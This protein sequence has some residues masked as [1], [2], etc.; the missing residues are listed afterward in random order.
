MDWYEWHNKYM[1]SPIL[2]DRL[3]T[4]CEQIEEFL[5][6]APPGDIR[7]LSICAGDGR[8]LLGALFDH[9]RAEDVVAR[10]IELEERLV[11]CGQAAVEMSGF[12][13]KIHFLH[14]DATL[15]SAY[16]DFAPAQLILLCGVFAHLTDPETLKLIGHLP[17]LCSPQGGVI[18]TRR[19][20]TEESQQHADAIQL[21]FEQHHFQRVHSEITPHE[22]R[23]ATYRYLGDPKPLP[24]DETLFEFAPFSAPGLELKQ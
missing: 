13:E 4:V 16:Q 1:R 21:A 8:D 18:W 3:K 10:L 19:V 20:K 22:T 11:D 14:G 17:A 15:S 6:K 5:L 7:V 23:V 9:P 2:M 12:S 24:L